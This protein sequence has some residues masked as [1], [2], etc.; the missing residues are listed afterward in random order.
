M[1]FFVKDLLKHSLLL[2]LASYAM[3]GY[4]EPS[5]PAHNY[6]EIRLVAN[7]VGFNA[8]FTDPRLRN[9]WGLVVSREGN[10]VV[11]DNAGPDDVTSYDPS[12]R[13]LAFAL[14][15]AHTPTGLVANFNRTDFLVGTAPNQHSA[16]LIYVTESGRIY[17]FN[18]RVSATSAELVV[19]RSALG[20]VYT[21]VAIASV[22]SRNASGHFVE[23]QQLYAADFG[24]GVINVFDSS[25]NFLSSFTDPTVPAG[26]VPFNVKNIDGL[27][28]VTFYDPT[29][30]VLG[31]GWVD[32]FRPDG[33]LV[34]QLIM[35]GAPLFSPWGLALAP[36]DWG[37]LGGSLLVGNHGD[38][39]INAFD[40]H[41]GA[42]LG[43]VT[44]ILNDEIVIPGLWSLDF[45][46]DEKLCIHRLYFSAG[47]DGDIPTG[48]VGTI[49]PNFF[50]KYLY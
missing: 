38:G 39:T 24:N 10:L 34:Q 6:R 23:S 12:G 7:E 41:T 42:F 48:L 26:Y 47:T 37:R 50:L 16:Q 49:L 36:S 28:Y 35:T 1:N 40:P 31:D 2:L 19:N 4:S 25:F 11:A 5:S 8:D 27:L 21:G 30:P 46:Y 13:P 18:G 44:D 29:G 22:R 14:S 45:R 15:G 3:T 33:T 32:I 20:S 43:S 17:A 9:P